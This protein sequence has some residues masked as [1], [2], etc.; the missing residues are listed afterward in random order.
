MWFEILL[1][2]ILGA[3]VFIS[4]I[5]PW[6]RATCLFDKGKCVGVEYQTKDNSVLAHVAPSGKYIWFDG[7]ELMLFGEPTGNI[8]ED[9]GTTPAYVMDT[10]SGVPRGYRCTKPLEEIKEYYKNT[11]SHT[12]FVRGNGSMGINEVVNE[13]LRNRIIYF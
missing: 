7:K 11:P 3:L 5:T 12:L 9:P 6:A 4:V 1:G 8:C 10:K 2:I 13:L